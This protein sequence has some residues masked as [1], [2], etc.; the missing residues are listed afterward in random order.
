MGL[1]MGE[2]NAKNDVLSAVTKNG[3]V[4]LSDKSS[5]YAC[6][7]VMD[8]NSM[9]SFLIAIRAWWSTRRLSNS[10]GG[11]RKLFSVTNILLVLNPS[12]KNNCEDWGGSGISH[13]MSGSFVTNL[14]RVMIQNTNAWL[15]IFQKIQQKNANIT[16]LISNVWA[17]VTR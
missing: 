8:S 4:C 1:K 16:T 14:S 17:L 10:T 11:D 9:L 13:W 15:R 3:F 2:P 7:I 6:E 5:I 12:R